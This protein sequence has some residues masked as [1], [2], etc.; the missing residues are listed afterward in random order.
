MRP[1]LDV[2]ADGE[3]HQVQTIRSRLAE[4]FD[5]SSA[6][7]E[8]L[9][10][11]G[12]VTT[13]QNR[14]GWATTYLYRVDLLERPRR[15]VYRIT[16]RG[17]Q[18]LRENPSRVDLKV[19]AQFDEFHEFRQPKQTGS[20]DQTLTAANDDHTPE[21][22]VD[23]AYRELRAALAAELLDRILD[24]TPER[25]EQLVLDVLHSMGY[26][27]SR[28]DATERLGQSGDEGVDGVV[29]E[30][31]LGLDLIYVQAKK[32][33]DQVHRPE[34]QKFFGALHGKRATKGV[35]MTTSG[36]SQG[37]LD[38]A[39]GANPRIILVDGKEIAQLMI[40]HNVGVS[41]SR[42]YELKRVDL[43]YFASD[44]DALPPAPSESTRP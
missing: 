42:R 25:F 18:V 33:K 32:W 22:R 28:D 6:D 38:Y 27:G 34:I 44:D 17:L 35:F 8:E 30:D 10:P 31:R 11:S 20:G 24:L 15:A 19:L 36:F 13:F 23:S 16:D 7:I 9:I 39:E 1:L 43:D 3:E 12:R 4:H 26:G 40:E 41:L 2:V 21:E 29:R 14:V 5:L 37:A